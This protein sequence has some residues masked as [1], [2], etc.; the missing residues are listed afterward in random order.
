MLS[1]TSSTQFQSEIQQI[2]TWVRENFSNH[3]D[4]WTIVSYVDFR[5]ILLAAIKLGHHYQHI[6]ELIN[7]WES[8]KQDVYWTVPWV[9]ELADIYEKNKGIAL[10]DFKNKVYIF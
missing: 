6:G 7:V 10:K 5:I 9:A 2:L 8:E 1:V 3:S 4:P